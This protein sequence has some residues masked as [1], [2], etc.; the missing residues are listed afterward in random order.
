MKLRNVLDSV[1]GERV[2]EKI[3]ADQ[4]ERSLRYYERYLGRPATTK[5]LEPDLINKW[6]RQMSVDGKGPTTIGNYRLGLLVLWNHLSEIG[7]MDPY[8]PRRIRK[9][10]A[11]ERPTE[12]WPIDQIQILVEAAKQVRGKLRG[13]M[14]GCD[15]LVAWVWV[16]MDTALRP[17]DLRLVQWSQVDLVK[18]TITLS[19]HKTRQPHAALLGPESVDALRAIEKWTDSTNRVFPIGKSGVHKWEKKLYAIA[20]KNGFGRKKGQGLGT[21]R[22]THATEVYLEHGAAAAAES[23]GHVGGVRTVKKHYIDAR[24]LRVGYLPRR[25]GNA[26]SSDDQGGSRGGTRAMRE[27]CREPDDDGRG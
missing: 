11:P 26:T 12:A 23:L 4:Y 7:K 17:G 6:L 24:S 8:H 19:Q 27:S 9:P 3:T 22:K 14:P 15:L 13:G 16:G 18:R 20:T 2:L 21:L 5:D 1:L 25:P 10:K